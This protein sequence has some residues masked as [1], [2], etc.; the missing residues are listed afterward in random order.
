MG[1]RAGAYGGQGGMGKGDRVG[2]RAEAGREW[3]PPPM[4]CSSL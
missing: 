2:E 1:D 4:W 3:A